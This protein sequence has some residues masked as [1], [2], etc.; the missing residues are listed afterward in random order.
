MGCLHV[1]SFEGAKPVYQHSTFY[2][3]EHRYRYGG[4]YPFMLRLSFNQV[5]KDQ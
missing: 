2:Q 5:L 1:V 4:D 3:Y